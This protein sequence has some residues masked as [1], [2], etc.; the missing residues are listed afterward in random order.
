MGTFTRVTIIILII[1]RIG[2][3]NPIA[4]NSPINHGGNKVAVRVGV[5]C[6]ADDRS[7]RRRLFT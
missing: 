7:E 1:K 4:I 2:C 5:N 6:N 3:R